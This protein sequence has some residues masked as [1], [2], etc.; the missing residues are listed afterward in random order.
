[1]RA[2][3]VL[4]DGDPTTN[5]GDIRKVAMVITQGK[6]VSPSKVYGALGIRP[7]VDDEPVAK[8]LAAAK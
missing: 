5:I 2:D 4:V 1:M 8:D 3:L 7:F 6:L